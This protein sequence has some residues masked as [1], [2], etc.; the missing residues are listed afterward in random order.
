MRACV[1]V[2]KL[3]YGMMC[4]DHDS[5]LQLCKAITPA[6]VGMVG[7]VPYVGETRVLYCADW[8]SDQS[9]VYRNTCKTVYSLK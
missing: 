5:A 3:Q 8:L 7:V 1:R 4:V 2:S 9:N 6:A